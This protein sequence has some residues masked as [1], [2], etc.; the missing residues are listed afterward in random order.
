MQRVLVCGGAGYV[1]SHMV[2]RLAQSGYQ[3]TVL[4][5]LSTGHAEACK[6]GRLLQMDILD[7]EALDFA[8]RNQHYDAVMHFS[9]R[10]VVSESM[11]DP[12]TYYTQNVV[13]TINLLSAM[14]KHGVRTLVFS[15]SA[16]V[17]GNPISSVIDE[18]HPKDP[19]SPYGASKLMVERIL[20][21]AASA[22]G[23]NSVSLRYFN[24]AGASPDGDIGESHT[25]ETHLI[26]SVLAVALNRNS[27]LRIFGD[28]Y[29]TPDGT[30]V[31]DY[32]HVDDL[33]QAHQLALEYLAR[34]PGA[35]V[36]NLGSGTGFSIREVIHAAERVVGRKIAY[37][38]EERRT[39]DP[40]Q[41]VASSDLARRELGWAPVHQSL[42]SIIETAWQWHQNARF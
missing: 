21:D 17:F 41:L 15:S 42:D 10:S 3:V 22:F 13:G 29:D 5:N 31:R 34:N 37:S 23:L 25:P 12:Y 35:H 2:K 33:A 18:K 32:V 39:G 26:P 6:W 7:V 11:Q 38:V 20:I 28:D 30:C 9:A 40:A 19:I 16:A 27:E 24:A 1:G 36:F 8:F 14:Q 4:D